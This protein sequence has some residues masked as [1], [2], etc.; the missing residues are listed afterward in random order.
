[1]RGPFLWRNRKEAGHFLPHRSHAHKGDSPQGGRLDDRTVDRAHSRC[2]E[3]AELDVSKKPRNTQIWGW[4]STHRCDE[5]APLLEAITHPIEI[6]HRSCSF[7]RINPT[8]RRAA[9][10]HNR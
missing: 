7:E 1:R 6:A 2:V 10:H 4:C 8:A 5:L 9:P 3:R